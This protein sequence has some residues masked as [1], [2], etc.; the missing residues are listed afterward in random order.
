MVER[1][2]EWLEQAEGDLKHAKN[3][4]KSGFYDF[5]ASKVGTNLTGNNSPF[6]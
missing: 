2:R 1:S 5:L 6:K 4:L 3:D